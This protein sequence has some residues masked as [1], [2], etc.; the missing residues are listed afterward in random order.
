MAG[1]TWVVGSASG[2]AF[3]SFITSFT[4][5]ADMASAITI[6]AGIQGAIAASSG[7]VDID[8][9]RERGARETIAS[10]GGIERAD[11]G[12]GLTGSKAGFITFIASACSAGFTVRIIQVPASARN[13]DWAG[14]TSHFHC[15][16]VLGSPSNER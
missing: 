15:F 16:G 1:A 3:A 12:A 10:V 14:K 4:S 2:N 13:N 11:F 8:L 6:F 7:A 5:R 9:N